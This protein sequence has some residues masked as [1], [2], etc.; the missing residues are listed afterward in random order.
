MK[1]FYYTKE[2]RKQLKERII[3][4]YGPEMENAK[5]QDGIMDSTT[6]ALHL[7]SSLGVHAT[8]HYEYVILHDL[9]YYPVYDDNNN[10]E[11]VR[12]KYLKR[13]AELRQRLKID[14]S[15]WKGHNTEN[16]DTEN[17]ISTC[18]KLLDQIEERIISQTEFIE[19][20]V[21][22][23]ELLEGIDKEDLYY[24]TDNGQVMR[25]LAF[26][27]LKA[28][29]M[30]L[31]NSET[32]NSIKILEQ[33]KVTQRQQVKTTQDYVLN[34]D[35]KS[36]IECSII[37]QY[38]REQGMFKN[39][40]KNGEQTLLS[41]LTKHSFKNYHNYYKKNGNGPLHNGNTKILELQEH[42]KDMKCGNNFEINNLE[43]LD[44]EWQPKD[45]LSLISF[46]KYK[47]F[48]LDEGSQSDA[49]II[50]ISKKL[51]SY[52]DVTELPESLPEFKSISTNSLNKIKKLF[53]PFFNI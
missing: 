20:S 5:F 15:Y 28:R 43:A 13:I 14:H 32:T 27:I 51:F 10:K 4:K 24:E 22:D 34:G 21:N 2:T 18:N 7:D 12:G 33:P 35:I 29:V 53:I 36:I 40:N 37:Y 49:D 17:T 30:E 11:L 25:D 26:S 1:L 16:A 19:V 45:I 9:K 39:M 23:L 44:F 42:I 41:N 8:V 46:L 3:N 6:I 47:K 38:L 50:N 31:E 48:I 52:I